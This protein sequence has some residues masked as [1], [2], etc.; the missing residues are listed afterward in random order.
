MHIVFLIN[1]RLIHVKLSKKSL[2]T[3]IEW[4]KVPPT[5]KN[6][7]SITAGPLLA[8]RAS[9]PMIS[10]EQLLLT[11]DSNEPLFWQNR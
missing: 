7:C 3:V 4:S 9:F 5:A 6:C 2:L 1:L 8:N 10:E 11:H